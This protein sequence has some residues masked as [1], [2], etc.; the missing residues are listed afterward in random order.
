MRI[1]H[2]ND[3]GGVASDENTAAIGGYNHVNR[4]FTH[5]NAGNGAKWLRG[6]GTGEAPVDPPL[7]PRSLKW[8]MKSMAAATS[9][10]I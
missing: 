7:D 1:H 5:C 8:W 2:G 6:S 9:I 3:R 10:S 4:Q